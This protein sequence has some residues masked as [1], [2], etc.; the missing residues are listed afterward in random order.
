MVASCLL[1]TMFHCFPDAGRW[2]VRAANISVKQCTP[3]P[4][5]LDHITGPC[6]RQSRHPQV[7]KVFTLS[8]SVRAAQSFSTLGISAR[9]TSRR[10]PTV[11][12]PAPLQRELSLAVAFLIALETVFE[13][14]AGASRSQAGQ[15]LSPLPSTPC[16]ELVPPLSF[17]SLDHHV[18]QVWLVD[19]RETEVQTKA[20]VRFMQLLIAAS[21]FLN[22]RAESSSIEVIKANPVTVASRR[23]TKV[24]VCPLKQI[25]C[26]VY[27]TVR[28]RR[29]NSESRFWVLVAIFNQKDLAPHYS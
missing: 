29:C 7:S 12:I 18:L 28:T 22:K 4:Q 14:Q 8:W 17:H 16:L 19:S 15:S 25:L 5:S 2:A 13:I 1:K 6:H 11:H 24:E 20:H 27:V 9:R 23:S 21:L 10:L 26:T 3:N